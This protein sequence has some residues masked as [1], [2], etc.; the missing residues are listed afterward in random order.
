MSPDKSLMLGAIE[1]QLSDARQLGLFEMA[2]LPGAD[3][4]SPRQLQP[5][6]WELVSLQV[7]AEQGTVGESLVGTIELGPAGAITGGALIGL[8]GQ[9]DTIVEGSYSTAAS[10]EAFVQVFT[11]V[12]TLT[13]FGT[14]L[15]SLNQVFGYD[16]LDTDRAPDA[17]GF[18][19]LVRVDPVSAAG[20]LDRAVPGR[21]YRAAGRRGR[22][23]HPARRS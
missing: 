21:Q 13:I 5:G 17:Y 2:R 3:A 15:P 19:N 6:T 1:R 8:D 14:L 4:P 11:E 12:R 18:V 7:Q 9:V 10:G 20:D 16:V 22:H 23:G